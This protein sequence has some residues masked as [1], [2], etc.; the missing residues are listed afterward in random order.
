MSGDAKVYRVSG[1]RRYRGHEPG[2]EFSALI[3]PGIAS[4]LIGRG[5]IEIVDGLR[6]MLE[7]GSFVLPIG[8]DTETGA[9]RRLST[10]ERGR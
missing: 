4:R 9:G 7:R 2:T 3:E 6:P 10:L 8:W 1:S 5:V